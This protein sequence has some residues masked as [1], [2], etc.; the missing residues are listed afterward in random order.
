M[1]MPPLEGKLSCNGF[2]I[3]AACD[4]KYF[5]SF[6]IPLIN[7]I[8]KNYAGGVHIHLFNPRSDQINFCQTNNVSFTYEYVD[9]HLFEA[10]ADKWKTAP[11]DEVEKSKYDR[12]LGAMEKSDD[13]D[14]VDRMQKT[15]YACA[16][17]IRL[18]QLRPSNVFAIDSDAVVRKSFPHI[19]GNFDFYMHSITGKKA[20]TLAGGLYIPDTIKGPVFLKEYSDVLKSYIDQDYLYWGIDQDVLPYI[21]KKYSVGQLPIAYI[22]W[23]MRPNSFVWTAKGKRKDLK[24][25]TDEQKKYA[26]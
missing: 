4:E 10:A 5:D 2:C 22:D 14:I 1:I 3:Y 12:I 11:L 23:E 15:Y 21:L 25:F 7:S 20:R 8:K 19:N 17:F 13:V 18:T 24:I 9:R 26:S 6:G 16:R